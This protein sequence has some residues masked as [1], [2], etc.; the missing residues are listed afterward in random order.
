MV[1]NSRHSVD[2]LATLALLLLSSA[3]VAA[4]P[5][6]ILRGDSLAAAKPTTRENV[7]GFASRVVACLQAVG[8]EYELRSDADFSVADLAGVRL[9][10]LPYNSLDDAQVAKLRQYTVAGG[11]LL[12]CF[13]TGSEQLP[14]LL[15]VQRG[16][17]QT[18]P[19]GEYRGL[20]F[21]QAAR[22]AAPA[23]PE[24]LAQPS[25]NA[26]ELTPLAGTRVLAEWDPAGPGGAV[27][28]TENSAGWFL[29]HVLLPGDLTAKGLLLTSF[30]ALGAPTLWTPVGAAARQR[31][32]ALV[33]RVTQRWT[34]LAARQDLDP[35][36]AT[37]LREQVASLGVRAGALPPLTDPATIPTILALDS[38]VADEARGLVYQLAASPEHELRGLWV[39]ASRPL[40]WPKIASQAKNAGLNAIFY[41]VA[42]GGSAV[43]PSAL[44]P[45]EEWSKERD[46]VATA[47]EA[48]HRYGLELH[49]WRVC[50]H[51]GSSPAAYRERLRTEGRISVDPTGQEA[52]F[53]N[54]GDP[55]N[56]ALELAAINEIAAKYAVDGVH[57]D[58][59]RY[60][61]EPSLD[62]DYGPVSRREFER[63]TG[64]SVGQWPAD[65]RHGELQ[66][67]YEDW[68]R[69]NINRVVRTASRDLH[70]A[71]PAICF[72]A[73]VWRNHHVYRY[74]IRQDWPLWVREGWL[75]LVVPMDY[76]TRAEDLAD[77]GRTQVALC[78]G[79]TRIAL[80]LGAWLL[81]EPADLLAQVEVCR[82]VGA[83]GW[84]LFSSNAANLDGLLA[85]LRQG[86]TATAAQPATQ[87]PTATWNLPDAILRHDSPGAVPAGSPVRCQ[88]V[89]GRGLGTLGHEF[90]SLAG[91]VSLYRPETGQELGEVG[92]LVGL[93]GPRAEFTG[94]FVAPQGP[95]QLVLQGTAVPA[96]AGRPQPW[97]LRGPLL[98]GWTPDELAAYRATL[99]V[100]Q[101]ARPGL[102]VGVYQ[103]GIG[104]PQLLAALGQLEG[105]APFPLHRFEAAHLQACEAVIVPQL[106]DPWPLYHGGGFEA[107]RTY[108]ERGGTLVLTR[109][110]CG[111]RYHP[112][113]F[114][115]LGWGDG[116]AKAK[117]VVASAAFRDRPA[118]WTLDHAYADH[119]TLQVTKDALVLLTNAA[120]RPVVAEGTYGQG[121]VI[122]DGMMTGYTGG[123]ADMPTAEAE[124]LAAWL[125]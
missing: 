64:Q 111:W 11:R 118:G 90:K 59:I 95:F 34:R 13:S 32:L 104:G 105:L 19:G 78:G 86:A 122:L 113:L 117:T 50:Y 36:R 43:Y 39:F 5:I 98:D 52:P 56:E 55:R 123:P 115:T 89:L 93:D 31:T 110:A 38:R 120:G 107:L 41:R 103:P 28:L 79:S 18:P 49:A 94:L 6:V 47:L 124:L 73:A 58:Y 80:G 72:S 57:L 109:D 33:D 51:L 100:P 17:L 8:V 71:R 44:L 10:V 88:V 77:I 75:D 22:E 119:L 125:K 121:R 26:F 16:G 66:R 9:V 108:V 14:A 101:T 60:T 37:Q 96:G 114:P 87:T 83:D 29:G 20:R 102:V 40:D 7:A 25:W 84:V 35:A 67:A 106:R 42:R 85:A 63:A 30:A 91:T 82:Q 1:P 116:Y 61:D 112:A 92:K 54:P 65:V 68:M 45:Q 3:A 62:F 2:R 21:T 27:A 97:R 76:V 12:A 53:A 23:L 15:G 70:A 48:C 99:A 46:E 24:S 69:E 81:N 74:L 4:P